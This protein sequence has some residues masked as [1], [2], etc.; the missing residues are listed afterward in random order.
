MRLGVIAAVGVV[1]GLTGC[2]NVTVKPLAPGDRSTNGLRF[3]GSAPYLLVS[4][5]VILTRKEELFQYRNNQLFSIAC[6]EDECKRPRVPEAISAAP[7]SMAQGEKP[8]KKE[9]AKP[10]DEQEPDEKSE[11][12]PAETPTTSGV[13]LTWLP[14]YCEPYAIDSTNVLSTQKLSIKLADGWRFDNLS[15]ETDSTTVVTKVLDTVAALVATFKGGDS[16]GKDEKK[17]DEAEDKAEALGEA[18]VTLRKVTVT[19]LKPGV[20]PLFTRPLLKDKNG[21]EL[22]N[23]PPCGFP[24]F[25]PGAIAGKTEQSVAWSIVP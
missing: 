3:Y 16:G 9:E 19:T 24:K 14:D 13:T 25:D 4:A 21:N 1:V 12:E 18:A 8:K 15:Q 11:D 7:Q 6:A 22:V 17:D 5:P 10:G 2:S 20:Y 23:E